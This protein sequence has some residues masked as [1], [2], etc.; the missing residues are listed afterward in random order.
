MRDTWSDE[1]LSSC[2]HA[3]ARRG[4]RVAQFRAAWPRRAGDH[5][6]LVNIWTLTCINW[7]RQEPYVRAWSQAYEDEG[8]IVIGVH[9]PEFGFEHEIDRVREAIEDRVIDYPVAV[10]N[11]YE[12]WN[13]FDNNYW[14]A[15]YFVDA[16]GVIRDQHFGEGRYE[17]SERKFKACSASSG[18]SCRPRNR[19]GSR[20]RLGQPGDAR[21][22]PRLRPR[23][24]L[25]V[26]AE[27]RARRAR[28][29][30]VSG[31]S[32]LQSV[33]ARGRMDYRPGARH[34]YGAEREHHLPLPGARRAP[35]PFS[36]GGRP[37]SLS[38]TSRRRGSGRV[39][40]RGRRRGGERPAR[41]RPSLPAHTRA[42]L[43]W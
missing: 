26:T 4:H 16:E 6:V 7:L 10:D 40:R 38:S 42:R 41:R 33:G 2:S 17:K 12:V 13:A 43:R 3:L 35:R 14:P 23:R 21:D 31:A 8:L 32:G 36:G 18:A 11:G 1:S 20:G 27:C 39:P 29:L 19:R 25:R 30:R 28:R 24:A 15:L 37:D 34:T 5:V 22:I 9:T